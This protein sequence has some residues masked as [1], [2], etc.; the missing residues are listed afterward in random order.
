MKHLAL[1]TILTLA[2]CGCSRSY[3]KE[4]GDGHNVQLPPV[5]KLTEE[6][7]SEA[8][9]ML[10]EFIAM[11]NA[12]SSLLPE[13]EVA[14]SAS[15]GD[16]S[17]VLSANCAIK[18]SESE[19]SSGSRD[20][21]VAVSLPGKNCP[22]QYQTVSVIKVAGGE[23]G[24]TA[25]GSVSAEVK[26]VGTELADLTSVQASNISGQVSMEIVQS[27]TGSSRI[28]ASVNQKGSLNYANETFEALVVANMN[29][30]V[31]ESSSDVE[32]GHAKT[33]VGAKGKN[34]WMLL[35]LEENHAAD[36]KVT[37][38]CDLNGNDISDHAICA[39]ME[40]TMPASIM[41]RVNL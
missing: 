15:T 25:N 40:E 21:N 13:N 1:V 38:T 20:E 28:K 37:R 2:V 33:V 11:E 24:M 6:Q 19:T 10:E 5:Q 12:I 27:T 23:S 4:R 35:T 7:E 17:A 30:T 39:A 3:R 22:L 32:E 16:I 29:L 34:G 18:H 8:L 14:T 36:G 31:K 41:K 9:A 26:V